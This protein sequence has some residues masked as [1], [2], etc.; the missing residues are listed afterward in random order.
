MRVILPNIGCLSHRSVAEVN[1]VLWWWSAYGLINLDAALAA[2]QTSEIEYQDLEMARSKGWLGETLHSVAVSGYE[3]YLLAS[4]PYADLYNTHTWVLDTAPAKFRGSQSPDAWNSFWTGT[5]PIQWLHGHL[6]GRE[7]S[8]H[9]SRDYDGK[10]RLWEAFS[11]SRTDN[12]CPII[13]TLETRAYNGG[14]LNKK[15]FRWARVFLSELEGAV[16]LAVFWAGA[17]RGAFKRILTKRI[18]SSVGPFAPGVTFSAGENIPNLKKQT[19]IV[20]TSD[21][22]VK[23]LDATS[24]DIE[25]ALRET[26]DVGFQL[27]IVASGPGAVRAVQLVMD[28]YTEDSNPDCEGDEDEETNLVRSDGVGRESDAELSEAE[29]RPEI[30]TSAQSVTVEYNGEVFQ[31][32]GFGESRVS[33]K[34]ADKIALCHAQNDA[35]IWLMRRMGPVTR[36]DPVVS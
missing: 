33:Q 36:D 21:A 22:K 15:Q 25:S 5:R 18:V 32:Q 34:D 20:E 1:G 9:F 16:D 6:Q 11:D 31:A 12:G 4:V 28:E 17:Y 29:P 13:W 14:S 23:P 27:F 2:N 19:R 24:C 26:V 35:D 30:F 8:Y 10:N 7:R 3:N